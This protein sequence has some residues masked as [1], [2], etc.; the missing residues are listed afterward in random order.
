[1]RRA[2]PRLR[3]P[4]KCSPPWRLLRLLF[5]ALPAFDGGLAA[6]G[7]GGLAGRR[8]VGDHRA[9][10]DGGVRADLDRRHQRAV[11]TDEGAVADAGARVVR[12]GGVAGDGAGA[13]V[14]LAP[15][16]GVAEVGQVVGLAALGHDRVLGLD[17]VADAHVLGEH[18]VRAQPRVRADRRG[19]LAARALHVV[20]RGHYRAGGP[21]HVTQAAA[22]AD[23]DVVAELD[24]ALQHHV[25]VQRDVASDADAAADVHARRVRHPRA[26]QAEFAHR[27][28]LECA[29]KL[30]QLPGIVGALGLHRVADHHDLR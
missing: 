26:S 22:R 19:A 7:H 6:A 3:R 10:A 8:V 14:G 5:G 9:G 15:D 27:A 24:L 13:D 11:G 17:E 4:W 1:W 16:A 23:A 30:R 28:A 12:V 18:G 2:F 20:V 21:V 25:H 29:L